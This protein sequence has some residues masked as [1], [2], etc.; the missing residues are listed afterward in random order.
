MCVSVCQSGKKLACKCRSLSLY[1]QINEGTVHV[2][3]HMGVHLYFMHSE[4][5]VVMHTNKIPVPDGGRWSPQL[6]ELPLLVTSSASQLGM[7]TC[8]QV[9]R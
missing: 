4:C 9:T 8:T 7:G 3:V 6:F 1:K 2:H 5:R